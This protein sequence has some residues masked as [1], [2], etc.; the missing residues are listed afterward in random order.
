[1]NK[2]G[3]F[4]EILAMVNLFFEVS[5]EYAKQF[6]NLNV[7]GTDTY[8]IVL[9]LLRYNGVQND[10]IVLVYTTKDR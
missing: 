5:T 10:D 3:T 8:I 7:I 9:K 4:V 6:S 2:R 1:M